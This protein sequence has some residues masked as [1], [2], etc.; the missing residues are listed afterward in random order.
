MIIPKYI[1]VSLFPW[2][3]GNNNTFN[4]IL[5][6]LDRKK[7]RYEQEYY[8][9][10]LCLQKTNNFEV[11]PIMKRFYIN[12]C[13]TEI[14]LIYYNICNN[15]IFRHNH[16]LNR[17]EIYDYINNCTVENNSKLLKSVRKKR[18][19]HGITL[20]KYKP[21]DPKPSKSNI[22][23]ERHYCNKRHLGVIKHNIYYM[24]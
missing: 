24:Y 15:W 19:Q 7:E 16:K 4:E 21:I 6:R 5:W 13:I 14:I 1:D 23:F 17:L 2:S 11:I 3:Y 18:R 8:T 22:V 12:L 9:L 10:I 20:P